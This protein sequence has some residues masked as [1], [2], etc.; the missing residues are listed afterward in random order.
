MNAQQQMQHY[1]RKY[2][3]DHPGAAADP[4]VVAAGM[5]REGY[6]KPRPVD[7]IS[8]CAEE[9]TRALR[10][11]YRT[12]PKGRKYRVNHAVRD[13]QGTLWADMDSA[14]KAFMEMAFAQRRKQI[15]G[16]CVQLKTDV[17][18]YNDK[19]IKDEPVNLVLD[20]TS[21][22]AEVQ[23]LQNHGNAA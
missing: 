5:I 14:T 4:Q 6:W 16:D 12:D 20:F 3:K 17:D 10:G 21:D 9:L 8:L 19:N 15:V 2:E 11:E 7:L 13:K 23:A 1:F 22:V 18:V